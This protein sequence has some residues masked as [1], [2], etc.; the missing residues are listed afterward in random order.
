MTNG[1]IKIVLFLHAE[2]K[3]SVF[4]DVQ[5][6]GLLEFL[7]NTRGIV[8]AERDYDMMVNSV[9]QFAQIYNHQIEQTRIENDTGD[10]CET[11][12]MWAVGD[13]AD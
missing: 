9:Q 13:F 6:M 5:T 8:N 11:S 4:A 2:T 3:T 10:T 1:V 7:Q 12:T